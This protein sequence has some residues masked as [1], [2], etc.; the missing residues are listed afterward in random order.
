MQKFK[1]TKRF[2]LKFLNEDWAECYIDFNALTVGDI[3]REM[4]N[5]LSMENK[6]AKEV[7][8]GLDSV[9][10]LLKSKFVSGFG[11]GE[12]GKKV[13]LTKED[14]ES[15]PAEV[16]TKALNFLSLGGAGNSTQ[17]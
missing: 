10:D 11:I 2:D 17:P 8:K 7:A 15:L 9:L 1:I 5:F 14:L 6:D 13:A 4:P 12:D 16:L 3:K